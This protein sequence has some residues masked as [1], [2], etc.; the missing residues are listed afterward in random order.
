MIAND[1]NVP[2]YSDEIQGGNKGKSHWKEMGGSKKRVHELQAIGVPLGSHSYTWANKQETPF[3]HKL[4][5]FI[6]SQG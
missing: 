1:F 6:V 2:Q 5:H 4:D 3:P